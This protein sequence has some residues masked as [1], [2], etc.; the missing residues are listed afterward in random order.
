MGTHSVRQDTAIETMKAVPAV[1]G[2]TLA[3]L[4]LNEWV[5]VA[6]FIYICLQSAFLLW[7]WHRAANKKDN[8]D[9]E[10]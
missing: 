10:K 5:A 3:T 9:I 8:Y 7:K 2:A 1:T 6:T 4:T